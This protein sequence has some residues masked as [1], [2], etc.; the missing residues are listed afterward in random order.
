MREGNLDQPI[1]PAG[2]RIAIV[3]R[4][5]Y[6]VLEKAANGDRISHLVDYFF[7]GLIVANVAAAVLHTVPSLG[8]TYDVYFALFER[9]S[10]GIFT[11]EYLLRVWSSVEDYRYKS[12]IGRLRFIFTPMAL[13]DLVAFL[14]FY[15][16]AIITIDL[17]MLRA[18]RL[19][20]L[21]RLVKLGRY[22]ESVQAMGTVLRQKQEELVIC[23]LMGSVL[24]VVV[25]SLMYFVEN[26][27]Q[28][29][30]FSSIPAAMW[31]GVA[32]LTTVGYGDIYPVTTLGRT[33]GA[34]IA[35]L[36]I[37]MFALPAGIL[38]SGFAEYIE[39]RKELPMSPPLVCPHCGKSLSD[40]PSSTI[41]S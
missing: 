6:Q 5:V 3:R 16:T 19:M 10:I 35:I 2:Q 28:P 18:I 21:M 20:R 34:L 29:D 40:P 4:R 32:T 23:A 24:L 15:L 30:Q 25:S 12:R 8:L 7:I 13:V 9:I 39:K 41:G 26:S 17:R 11:I 31:W 37:G 1:L 36:G 22:S 38:A 33:L 27:V 14:P